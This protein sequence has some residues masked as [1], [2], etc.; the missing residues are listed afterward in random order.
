MVKTDTM[1]EVAHAVCSNI[2][3]VGTRRNLTIM[4]DNYDSFTWNVYQYLCELGADVRVYRND[5]ITVE[6]CEKL[7]PTHIVISPG[8]GT[9]KEAGVSEKVMAHFAGKLPILG[10][11]LG[12]QVMSEL[13][14]ATVG[15]A[16]EIMH[17]KTSTISHDGK[18]L[19]RGLP[20]RFDIIRYHSLTVLPETLTPEVPLVVTS[21]TDN[22]VIMGVRH[23]TFAIEGV[24]YHP[25]SVLSENGLNMFA[26]FLRL[27]HGTWEQEGISP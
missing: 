5:K 18:G 23:K 21:Q 1:S 19:Y 3:A 8:P 25:E 20:E 14:G 7:N 24:Q 9:P 27:T 13:Y 17:G 10:V 2:N 4:I 15:L 26:N 16:P 22:G 11:C 12:E 6:E